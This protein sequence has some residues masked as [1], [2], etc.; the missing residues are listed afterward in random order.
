MYQVEATFAQECAADVHSGD[1][2]CKSCKK[3][4]LPAGPFQ[5]CVTM[6]EEF[7]GSCLD[8]VYG[9]AKGRCSFAQKDQN[10]K[11]IS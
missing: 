9:G 2:A 3:E 6:D 10:S 5:L 4:P 11:Y 7:G 1:K 8:C